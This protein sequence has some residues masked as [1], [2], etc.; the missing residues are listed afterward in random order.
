MSRKEKAV[1]LYEN[2]GYNCAQAVAIAYCDVLSMS[3]EQ[4]SATFSGF[5]GGFGGQH[6]V[7]GAISAMTA[8][9]GVIVN[10]S[11]PGMDEKKRIYSRIASASKEFKKQHDSIICRSLLV[12]AKKTNPSAKPCGAY[13]ATV[14]DLIDKSIGKNTPYA[15]KE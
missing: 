1:N 14:C 2:G 3:E 7:C 5:G 4:A 15:E 6:E 10:A 11:Q 8:I 12:Q 9:M 13:I